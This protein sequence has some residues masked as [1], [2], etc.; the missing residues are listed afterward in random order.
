[1]KTAGIMSSIYLMVNGVERFFIEKIRVNTKYHIFGHSIT[2]AEIIST[3]FFIA[4]L[5]MLIYILRKKK[6][7][8]VN[9]GI[10]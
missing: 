1:M 10:S 5:V 8:Q 6:N 9:E 3:I 2:Q 7:K 4:G